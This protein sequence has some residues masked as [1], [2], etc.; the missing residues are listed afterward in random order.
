[1]Y[2]SI[3][4]PLNGMPMNLKKKI[5]LIS[6]LSVFLVCLIYSS[7][8]VL[9]IVS[10]ASSSEEQYKKQVQGNL[11]FTA[12][13][14]YGMAN[15]INTVNT[16]KMMDNI[17]IG[18]KLL[19]NIGV[20]HQGTTEENVSWE[21]INQ[22]TK[23]PVQVEIPTL[24]FGDTTVQKNVSFSQTS[25]I[26]D[27]IGKML[28]A[29]VTIFQRMNEKGDML[30]ISTNVKNQDGRRAVS[31]YIPAINPDGQ[32]NPVVAK[33]L[34]GGVFSGRAFVVDSWYITAYSP[35][36]N[37]DG[38]VIGAFYVGVAL[39][40]ATAAIRQ[41]ILD[42]KIGDSGYVFVIGAKG[43]QKGKYL[44]SKDGVQDGEVILDA[45][46]Y[47]GR[48]F[49]ETMVHKSLES[50]P[51]E[52]SFEHYRWS[53]KNGEASD[54]TT[55]YIYFEPWDWIIG[56]SSYDEEMSKVL[57]IN[58]QSTWDFI[59]MITALSVVLIL[60]SFFVIGTR[61]PV[62][63]RP[64]EVVSYHLQKF[65]KGD[66]EIE[67]K[68]RRYIDNILERRKDE[69]RDMMEALDQITFFLRKRA[70]IA[71]AIANRDFSVDVELESDRD[72]LGIAFQTM[73][74]N[75]NSALKDV[76]RT[77]KTL[78]SASH[79]LGE[80][81]DHLSQEASNHAS[82]VEEVSASL[83]EIMN[84]VN[85]LSHAA[86]QTN[87]YSSEAQERVDGGMKKLENL[88]AA[89]KKIEGTSQEVD[90]IISIIDGIAFQTNLLALN[91]AVE[92]A[93][94]GSHGKG[95]AVVAEE[96]RNL[97]QRSTKAAKDSSQL[98]S[99][100][101]AEVEKG[102]GLMIEVEES[103]NQINESMMESSKLIGEMN[104]RFLE[105]KEGVKQINLAMTN[106]SSITTKTA[107]MAEESASKTSIMRDSVRDL[108]NNIKQFKLKVG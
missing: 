58:D 108:M 39:K 14:V 77:G 97:S 8:A 69:F 17:R 103:L 36:L 34:S 10:M 35:I 31:T 89:I 48:K 101:I 55:A 18:K 82:T 27:S 99:N 98:I 51:R 23:E 28:G 6:L 106:A 45:E 71:Q 105:Q 5:I 79:D 86:N 73:V 15:A 63:V 46:S 84:S 96:V 78:E 24:K 83:E 7:F 43:S 75:L 66:F 95:F 50:N 2:I 68:Y 26:V 22:Y 104:S 80:A 61:V 102:S 4:R 29:T 85:E 57:A 25:P 37:A 44:I 67:S 21:A 54:R 12:Q 49:V 40:K 74:R 38:E 65:A 42:Y 70:Q 32:R 72:S 53:E 62:F 87:E 52:V 9:Q 19:E 76:L 33:L 100:S 59:L 93:R 3:Y 1:M 41:A 88:I 92:A 107:S 91:A 13:H 81:A 60:I 16:E 64:I 90:S 56:I 47:D 11:K 94:A 30:R 20:A